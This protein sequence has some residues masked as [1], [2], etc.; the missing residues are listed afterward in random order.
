MPAAAMAADADPDTEV[1]RR[2]FRKGSE[3][4]L[5]EQYEQ[6]VREFEAA[7]VLKPAPELDYNIARCYDRLGRW[8]EALE[9]YQRYLS[10]VGDAADARE[11]RERVAILESRVQKPKPSPVEEAAPLVTPSVSAPAEAR[12]AK[13]R[14]PVW[15]PVVVGVVALGA[16]A[17]GLGL[18]LSTA[19]SFDD[20]KGSCAPGC[21]RGAWA[22]LPEREQAG[23]GL[24]AVGG[25]LAAAD[26]ALAVLAARVSF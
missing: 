15:A 9:A 13:R 22:G 19:S 10:R 12:P 17:S 2:H 1:A 16:L 7:R 24:M 6:A 3:L 11:A 20:L 14:V 23:I 5:A 18:Y 21:D 26:V 8:Q 25:V 4:Y